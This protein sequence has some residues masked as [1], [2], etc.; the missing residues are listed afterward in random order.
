MGGGVNFKKKTTTN[1]NMYNAD[2]INTLIFRF[3]D[4]TIIGPQEVCKVK[5]TNMLE[6]ILKMIQ[7]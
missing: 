7:L 2:Y 1:Q 4:R 6:T 3:K 5:H